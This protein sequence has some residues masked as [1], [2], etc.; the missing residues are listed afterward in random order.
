MK[1][2][3][4][5]QNLSDKGTEQRYRAEEKMPKPNQKEKPMFRDKRIAEAIPKN[6]P[7]E[8]HSDYVLKAVEFYNRH[9]Q[10]KREDR[11]R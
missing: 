5:T 2:V 7:P 9:L 8:K 4:I 6:I 3:L 10:R 11:G 1:R